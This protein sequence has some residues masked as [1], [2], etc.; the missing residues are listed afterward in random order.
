MPFASLSIRCTGNSWLLQV[1]WVRYLTQMKVR[2]HF[3]RSV[4]VTGL[5]MTCVYILM[6]TVGYDPF[7]KPVFTQAA[8]TQLFLYLR[9]F[10][11]RNH[12]AQQSS[13]YYL[14]SLCLKGMRLYHG[15]LTA[16]LSLSGVACLRNVDT[17]KSTRD[18]PPHNQE[19]IFRCLR[20]KCKHF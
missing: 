12:C 1:N 14:R 4:I 9:E 13:A 18:L 11:V 15:E 5:A 7:L 19:H 8:C 6:G 17:F 20:C 2:S 3:P 16:I 10:C